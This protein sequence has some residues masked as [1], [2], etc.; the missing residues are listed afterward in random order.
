MLQ[1]GTFGAKKI[2]LAVIGFEPLNS[3][4]VAD[5]LTATPP[6][7]QVPILRSFYFFGTVEDQ[8]LAEA[9]G[10][11]PAASVFYQ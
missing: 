2:F 9:K 8:L 5:T 6:P 10:S 4:L 1:K 11:I 3:G 7:P